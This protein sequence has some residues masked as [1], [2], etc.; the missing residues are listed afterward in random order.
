VNAILR[1]REVGDPPLRRRG[2]DTLDYGRYPDR[3]PRRSNRP[4]DHADEMIESD[5][6]DKQEGRE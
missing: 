3:A 5:W 2:S 4:D 1:E 6:Y